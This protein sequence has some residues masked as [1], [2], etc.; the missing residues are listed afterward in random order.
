MNRQTFPQKSL[1]TKKRPSQFRPV[2]IFIYP[3]RLL[4]RHQTRLCDLAWSARTIAKVHDQVNPAKL[5]TYRDT[6]RKVKFFAGGK[7]LYRWKGWTRAVWQRSVSI[8]GMNTCCV[9]KVCI[10]GRN[11]HVLCGK[12]PYRWN[13]GTRAVWQRSVSMEGRNTCCVAKI[14]IDGRDQHVICG[15][16][17]YWCVAEWFFLLC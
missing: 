2:K 10:D 1:Q 15:K 11:E 13:G 3:H 7:G 6:V 17:P 8:E 5:W 9:A 12:G 4:F 16:G 14:R